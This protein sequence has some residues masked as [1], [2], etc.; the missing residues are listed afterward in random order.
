MSTRPSERRREPRV[1]LK[2]ALIV[3]GTDANDEFFSVETKSVDLSPSGIGVLMDRFLAEGAVVKLTARAYEFT[4]WAAVRSTR[5]DKAVGR[6]IV[7]FE[8]LDGVQN[9]IV[10]F[11]WYRTKLEAASGPAA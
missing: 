11:S 1:N 3:S 4:T 5:F 2:I 8:Y 10:D 9:P 7:G 6:P